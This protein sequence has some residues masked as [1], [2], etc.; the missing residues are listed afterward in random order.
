METKGMSLPL[1]WT[2][3]VMISLMFIG[4]IQARIDPKTIVGMWLFDENSS[5]IAIDT[6]GRG[7][8]GKLV[9]QPK[10]IKGQFGSALQFDGNNYVDCGKVLDVDNKLTLSAW[11]KNSGK[12]RGNVV[13]KYEAQDKRWHIYIADVGQPGGDDKIYW[14][15]GGQH[16]GTS[17]IGQIGTD[18]HHLAMVY[19]GRRS[20][21]KK[22]LKAYID[23][24]QTGLIYF[25]TIPETMPELQVMFGGI[26]RFFNGIVDEVGIFKDALSLADIRK[27]MKQGLNS[28]ASAPSR[29]KLAIAWANVK[30]E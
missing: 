11:V 29:N 6:S 18:W 17:P 28:A 15:I 1:W 3:L 22:R 30:I 8:N 14:N 12:S 27:I 10:W 5:Q 4:Q 26:P 25:G 7:N 19:D 2:G 24:K 9:N 20:E 23:A 13:G 16:W 21:N